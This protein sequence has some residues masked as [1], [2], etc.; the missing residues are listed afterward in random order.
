[1][2]LFHTPIGNLIYA[3]GKEKGGIN[4][5]RGYLIVETASRISMLKQ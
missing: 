1:M 5:K 2:I 3:K 4:K